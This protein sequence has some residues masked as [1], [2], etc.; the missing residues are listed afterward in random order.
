MTHY[1][2]RLEEDVSAIRGRVQAV[3]K[4]V[5]LGLENAVHATLTLDRPLAS[6]VVLGDK[7][8]NR[9]IRAID[10]M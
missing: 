7:P 4:D 2:Q 8:I 9:Q 6:Q 1:E 3:A 10:K 5:E